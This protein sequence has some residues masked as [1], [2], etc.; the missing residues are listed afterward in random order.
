MKME[1]LLHSGN[2]PIPVG[3]VKPMYS[4]VKK[5]WVTAV[6]I[7]PTLNPADYSVTGHIQVTIKDE[8]TTA[9]SDVPE[10]S[11]TPTA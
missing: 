1:Y 9:P 11:A 8:A 10:L 6:G 5:G 4:R 2:V 7:F 3:S